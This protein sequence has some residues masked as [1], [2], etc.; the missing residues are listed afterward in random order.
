LLLIN[1]ALI[2]D[3]NKSIWVT[4][5]A[6]SARVHT[7]SVA[8][9]APGD[10][11]VMWIALLFL[12]GLACVVTG[13]TCVLGAA[14]AG[15]AEGALERAVQRVQIGLLWLFAGS[16][17]NLPGVMDAW[18][19]PNEKTAIQVVVGYAAFVLPVALGLF[20][21]GL[22]Q[23]RRGQPSTAVA[24]FMASFVGWVSVGWAQTAQLFG[25]VVVSIYFQ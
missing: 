4:T 2:I 14:W 6:V 23:R 18:T 19:N 13:L 17:C 8:V 25:L 20:V 5:E 1:V 7:G 12:V 3:L 16:L 24:W 15:W 11:V 22:V 10:E 9:G 21:V